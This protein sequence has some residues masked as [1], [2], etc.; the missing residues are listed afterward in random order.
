VPTQV[1]LLSRKGLARWQV[2][3]SGDSGDGYSRACSKTGRSFLT[4]MQTCGGGK[5][6]CT[7]F[8]NKLLAAE[9]F[10]ELNCYSHH[11]STPRN[12]WSKI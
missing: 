11:Q 12:N 1:F 6:P 9:L 3:V 5:I 2:R 4:W 8:F 10:N 7:V